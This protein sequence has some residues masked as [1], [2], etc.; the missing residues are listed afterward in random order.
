M[1]T[2]PVDTSSLL[3]QLEA[4]PY[5]GLKTKYVTLG[6]YFDYL[7]HN[8]QIMK[9]FRKEYSESAL[10]ATNIEEY[11]GAYRIVQ[12]V[13]NEIDRTTPL[14]KV[15]TTL[16]KNF[17]HG[18][19]ALEFRQYLKEIM[20]ERLDYAFADAMFM[21]KLLE[22][23]KKQNAVLLIIGEAHTKRLATRSVQKLLGALSAPAPIEVT[24][25]S[26]AVCHT[27]KNLQV[28]S[29]CHKVRYC[30]IE[31]QKKDWLTHKQNCSPS[32]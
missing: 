29:R 14:N 23:L 1:T 25:H 6:D 27:K 18:E 11:D 7:A 15:F 31:C 13:L 30:G 2:M 4:L 3:A 16:C 19:Q 10:L 8:L 21:K 28:C 22:C 12:K 24:V 9:K 5:V 32:K 20:F 26:C 17:K